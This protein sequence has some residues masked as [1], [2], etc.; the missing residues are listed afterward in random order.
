MVKLRM[1]LI[2]GLSMFGAS[3]ALAA[4]GSVTIHNASPMKIYG[5]ALAPAGTTAWVE[6]DGIFLEFG[7]E[8]DIIDV[9]ADSRA[10]VAPTTDHYD[11]K[12]SASKMSDHKLRDCI[13]KNVDFSK[14]HIINFVGKKCVLEK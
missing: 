4:E 10:I 8:G 1:G 14:Q 6:S 11:V 13:I 3:I 7:G 12:V 9:G 2:I 5:I